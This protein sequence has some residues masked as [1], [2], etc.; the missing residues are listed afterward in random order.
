M[1]DRRVRNHTQ[2]AGVSSA[3]LRDWRRDRSRERSQD[4]AQRLLLAY[5]TPYRDDYCI[6]GRGFPELLLRL[7][8]EWRKRRA[9]LLR[10]RERVKR[11]AK[12]WPFAPAGD[13]A[14]MEAAMRGEGPID[15]DL[16]AMLSPE[17]RALL[18]GSEFQPSNEEIPE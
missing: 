15:S 17:T 10:E 5:T 8:P 6:N 12:R 11:L 13:V 2:P 16:L 18:D 7:R 14:L 4:A 9:R 3:R 1:S